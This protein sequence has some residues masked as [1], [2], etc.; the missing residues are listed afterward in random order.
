MKALPDKDRIQWLLMLIA[1]VVVIVIYR[2][3]FQR[4]VPGFNEEAIKSLQQETEPAAP[5]N[6]Q[7]S[8]FQPSTAADF[9]RESIKEPRY[10]SEHPL[11]FRVLF[12]KEGANPMLGVVDESG[13]SGAGYDIAYIDENMNGD[14]TDD[15]AR[16]FS[17]R[18]SGSRAGELEPKF[19][20][21]GPFEGQESAKYAINIYSLTPGFSTFVK[22]NEYYFFSYLDTGDWHYFFINGKIKLFPSV[23][24]ALK[25]TPVLLGGECKWEISSRIQ[26]G[27]SLISAGLKDRNG[28]TL[29]IVRQAGQ[30]V[31]P[32]LTLIKDGKVEIKEKMKFG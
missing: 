32:T 31:S 30:T 29:R 28:C 16:K 14:L 21:K 25:G 5:F 11:Y 3:G 15:T 13:G 4:P 27:K 23:D 20:F 1:V 6:R 2:I 9:K 26:D 22:E 19:E 7:D 10:Y 24:E 12:G 8:I 17:R 18:E